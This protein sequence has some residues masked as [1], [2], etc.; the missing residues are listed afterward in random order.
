VGK[1]LRI[2]HLSR[3]EVEVRLLRI[4]RLGFLAFFV[5]SVE[6]REAQNSSFLGLVV[7]QVS[8]GREILLHD[9]HNKRQE[10]IDKH[11]PTLL[12]VTPL[13]EEIEEVVAERVELLAVPKED[14]ELRGHLGSYVRDLL[15]I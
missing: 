9:F 2:D 12:E 10:V 11:L 8:C 4:L 15:F 13:F 6:V 3:L 5:E 14:Q 7:L 1:D